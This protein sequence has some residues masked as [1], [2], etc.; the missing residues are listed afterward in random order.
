LGV[1]FLSAS[2]PTGLFFCFYATGLKAADLRLRWTRM[3][4]LRFIAAAALCV[5]SASCTVT[6]QISLDYV[7]APGRVQPGAPDFSTRKFVDRRDSAPTHLGTVR[8]Q[9]GTPVE[10]VETRLP[11]ADIVTNAFGHGLE[12][13]GMLTSPR[14][15]RYLVSGEV[16]DLYCQMLVRPY[17]YARV[18]VTVLEAGSGEIL[19]SRVFEGQRQGAAYLPGSGSPIPILSSLVSGALQ[20][21]VDKALDDP[22][23]RSRL[24]GPAAP[25]PGAPGGRPQFVPGML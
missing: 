7:P 2:F 12:S 4:R 5:V 10:Q 19:F 23:L 15:A 18:R 20:D 1:F 24:G 6:S 25:P 14:G 3:H 9:I 11:V 17:G 8:T 21:V 22:G 16:L 13:R